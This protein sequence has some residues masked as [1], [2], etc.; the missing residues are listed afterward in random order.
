MTSFSTFAA[1]AAAV[2]SSAGERALLHALRRT[3]FGIS[4]EE[5]ALGRRMGVYGWL[6]RQLDYESIDDSA[7]EGWIA[8][9]LP[10]VGMATEDIDRAARDDRLTPQRVAA[11]LQMAS[12]ARAL[13]SPRRLYEMMVDFWTNHFNVA[14]QDINTRLLKTADDRDVIRANAMGAFPALLQAS[15]RSPAMLYYLDNYSNTA[16]GPNE[17][18][19][20][21]LLELHTLG[22]D[23]GYTEQDVAEVARCLTGWSVS[24]RPVRGLFRFYPQLHDQGAKTVLGETIA[25]GGGMEDGQ[26]VLDLLARH[27]ST[28]NHIAAK[29]CR[30]FVA[31]EPE[32]A[33]VERVA[34]RFSDSAGDVRETLAELLFSD[35]FFA[36]AGAKFK[37]PLELLGSAVAALN[38]VPGEAG[39]GT[40][41]ASLN[42][43]GQSPFG[44]APPTGYPDRASNW[45]SSSA[46]INRWNECLILGSGN[47][48]DLPVDFAPVTAAAQSAE[49]LADAIVDT[50]LH[51][52]VAPADRRI[53]VDF[54]TAGG[55]RFRELAPAAAALV[56]ASPYFQYR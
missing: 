42:L 34:L 16:D 30:R 14:H 52:S 17:N 1:N 31:D 2:D 6:E 36:S 11:E 50:L 20:R 53:L 8:E 40:L 26:R 37:R 46:L 32:P 18:Y 56:I 19:A 15:A 27:P 12:I 44:W 24:L 29:L 4:P 23:G 51:A 21:E 48:P 35:A 10:T 55:E 25:A 7:L 3:G 22:V 39:L 38:I 41:R 54:L 13:F 33:L 9:H 43:L 49:Q 47:K 5:W 28:A 45:V